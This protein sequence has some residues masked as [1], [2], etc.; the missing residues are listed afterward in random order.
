MKP[1]EH[2]EEDSAVI[3]KLP[4]SERLL[5]LY[6]Q[7]QTS[8]RAGRLKLARSIAEAFMGDHDK[9]DHQA[10]DDYHEYFEAY[11]EARLKYEQA[12][13]RVT[14]LVV[15]VIEGYL[16]SNPVHREDSSEDDQAAAN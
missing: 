4:F 8:D 3:Q 13:L 16:A 11:E 5:E 6:E 7:F 10:T 14:R 2:E 9:T 1:E 12:S 15:H